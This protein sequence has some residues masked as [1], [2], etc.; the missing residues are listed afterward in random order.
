MSNITYVKDSSEFPNWKSPCPKCGAKYPQPSISA[1]K[2][3][4]ASWCKGCGH[5]WKI[6][7]DPRPQGWEETGKKLGKTILPREDKVLNE[8]NNNPDVYELL[9]N[10]EVRTKKILEILSNEMPSE[11]EL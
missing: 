2:D 9:T 5:N 8:L 1:R 4:T 10:I 3:G 6:G 7:G 11:S